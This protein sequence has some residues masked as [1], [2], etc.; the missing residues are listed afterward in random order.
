MSTH[1]IRPDAAI[2]SSVQ[3]TTLHTA[4]QKGMTRDPDSKATTNDS[5]SGPVTEIDA[6]AELHTRLLDT[7]QGFDKILEKSEPEFRPVAAE[8]RALHIHQAATIAS[9]LETEGH[10]PSRDGSMFGSVNKMVVTVR[11][12]FDDISVNIMDS[13]VHGEKHVLEA[14]DDA[15][16]HVSD[17]ERRRQLADARAELIDLLDRHAET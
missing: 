7:I 6:L 16:T 14:Y 12:W 8:F 9:M 3:Q 11:S 17:A 5:V 10:D 2:P 15:L 13:V 4:P 1:S